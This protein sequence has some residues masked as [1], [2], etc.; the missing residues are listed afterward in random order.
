MHN[1]NIAELITH[2]GYIGIFLIVLVETSTPIGIF[3]PGDTLL[4]SIGILAGLG[5]INLVIAM[6][7]CFVALLI[8]SWLGYYFGEK[9]GILIFKKNR[10]FYLKQ[11]HHEKIERFFVKFGAVSILLSKFVPIVRSGISIFAGIGKMNKKVFYINTIIG[12]LLWVMIVP[13]LGKMLGEKINGINKYVGIIFIFIV[14]STFVP[15][16]IKS[17]IDRRKYKNNLN[18]KTLE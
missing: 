17:I 16:V 13:T 1:I 5:K 12:G 4:L 11:N 9:F 18:K 3:L 8:G 2:I 6:I 10:L 7:V 14:L 15:S